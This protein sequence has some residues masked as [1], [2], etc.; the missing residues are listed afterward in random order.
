MLP[1]DQC[2]RSDYFSR[3]QFNLRLVVE[4]KLLAIKRLEYPLLPMIQLT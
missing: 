1:S 3:L 4:E 2:F